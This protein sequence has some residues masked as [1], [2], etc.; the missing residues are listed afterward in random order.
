MLPQFLSFINKNRLFSSGDRI[1]LAVSGGLDS[2]VMAWLFHKAGFAFGIAHCNF[3]LRGEESEAD[4]K[5]VGELAARLRVPFHVNHF[6]TSEIAASAKISAQMAA[7]D[8]RYRWFEEVRS[9]EKYDVVATAHHLD[10]QAET[11]L[12]NLV[13]G[14]GIAGLHGI[15]PLLGKVVRPMLFASRS[16][17]EEFAAKE[18]IRFRVDSSN[19]EEKYLRNKIRLGI[20]PLLKELNPGFL[21]NLT[22]EIGW[23]RASEQAARKEIERHIPLILSKH[24]D[25]DIIDLSILNRTV[26]ME[27]VA[28]EIF[29]RYG[30]NTD[31]VEDMIG[32]P[33]GES[34]RIFF[35]YSHR[36]VRDRN[37]II[38]QPLQA[39]SLSAEVMISANT[40][41]IANPCKMSFKILSR[42]ELTT[43][44]AGK[45]FA[46]L[47]ADRLNFPLELRKWKEGDSFQPFGMKG[48]KKVS[49]FLIDQKLSIPDKENTWVLLS[50]GKIVWLVGHRI[51]H[52]FRI[53]TNTEKV[54][55][56]KL[57]AA[58]DQ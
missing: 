1:L 58:N 37:R 21:E 41:R 10:D 29:S 49:D 26:A 40:R 2:V 20:L 39:V 33:E 43:I 34:G 6:N 55:R 50:A 53:R 15:M 42:E 27:L 5:F 24:W 4:E 16:E 38:V 56:I 51:D 13:R 35:S 22:R 9:S 44:P 17:I 32:S 54:Y 28:W 23:L 12:I 48:S 18:Q 8:L 47:D 25:Q 45:E 3:R 11:F 36:A 31:V 19:Q 52:R 30:F 57:R 7:R 14:T 46:C